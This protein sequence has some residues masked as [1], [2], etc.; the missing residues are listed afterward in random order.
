MLWDQQKKHLQAWIRIY[1]IAFGN[2][3]Y[4]WNYDACHVFVGNF[5]YV[6]VIIVGAALAL[7]GYISIGIIV[8]FMVYVRTFS[9]P[10]SQIAQG[11]YQ[12]TTS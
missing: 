8:A 11:I 2:L 6:L 5:S 10:L 4:L 12:L 9:Q 1:M 3:I 7:E